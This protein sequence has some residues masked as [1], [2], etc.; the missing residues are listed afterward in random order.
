MKEERIKFVA[1]YQAAEVVQPGNCAFNDPAA[2]KATQRSAVPGGEPHAAAA[3]RADKFDP[4]RGQSLAQ[5]IAVGCP[6][7]AQTPRNVRSDGCV[8]QRLNLAD[9]GV[10]GVVD[11]D[12][13]GQAC[14]IDENDELIAFALLGGTSAITPFLPRQTCRRRITLSSPP[15]LGGRGT[16]SA[17]VRLHPKALA[18]QVDESLPARHF[19]PCDKPIY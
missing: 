8:N 14:S 1:D 9:F 6:V 19:L 13:Q 5:R 17:C 2:T 10:S 4:T 7:V 3:M 12:G 11:S 18:E 15:P 16:R